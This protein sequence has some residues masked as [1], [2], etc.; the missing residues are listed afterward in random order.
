MNSETSLAS[1]IVVL[2]FPP[3]I[4]YQINK[5]ILFRSLDSLHFIFF[6]LVFFFAYH[7]LLG[8]PSLSTAIINHLSR[9]TL[10][11]SNNNNNKKSNNTRSIKSSEQQINNNNNDNN[12]NNDTNSRQVS[13]TQNTG[14]NPLIVTPTNKY[15]EI[16]AKLLDTILEFVDTEYDDD[17]PWNLIYED[18]ETDIK[19]YKNSQ[20]S[21]CCFKVTGTM[22]NTPQT[23]FDLLADVRRRSE[24]DP[25]TDEAGIIEIIDESTR[26]QYVKMKSVFPTSARDVVTIGYTTQ[27]EDSRMVMVNKSIEHKLCPEKS[28]II[29]LEAGCAGVVVSPIKDQPN[30]CFV[31]QIADAN[32]KGWIP[33]SVITLISTRDMPAS[34][35]KLNKL[36]AKMPRQSVSKILT[37][38]PFIP[39]VPTRSSSST[40]ISSSS[41]PSSLQH[42]YHRKVPS[43]SGRSLV[44]NDNGTEEFLSNEKENNNNRSIDK[45][46]PLAGISFWK[47]FIQTIL[48]FGGDSSQ[49]GSNLKSTKRF[50]IAAFAYSVVLIA[51]IKKWRNR[52]VI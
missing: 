4:L 7:H 46:F 12:D 42:N 24:W 3:M 22:E 15:S 40:S 11:Q 1:L 37:H 18:K 9:K 21:D 49:D 48:F 51:G 6:Q 17:S 31:V 10:R 14:R 25:M 13:S 16:T 52:N 27:L 28:G 34:I 35:K 2:G 19:V 30:K 44:K 20:V 26:V 45:K 36:L 39:K 5:H 47:S 43:F 38:T 33:K 29:R 32:P 50:V 41:T 8:I 23:T